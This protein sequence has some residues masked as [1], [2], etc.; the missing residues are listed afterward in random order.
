MEPR[1][2]FKK[3]RYIAALAVVGIIGLGSLG[4]AT[5]TPVAPTSVQSAAAIQAVQP[6]SA[7]VSQ[8]RAVQPA[9]KQV[10][11]TSAAVDQPADSGLSNDNHYVNSSGNTVHSPAYS[12]TVPPGASAQ[13][14]DGTYSFSQHRRG[15][16]SHHGG[17]AQWL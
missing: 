1:P 2:W 15:T 7:V 16:C 8:T 14:G 4:D 5:T 13:C 9:P 17:V 6:S 3:K 11:Q 10:V 12:D